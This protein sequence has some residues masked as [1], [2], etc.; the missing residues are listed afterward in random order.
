M[1][2]GV[3]IMK[4]PKLKSSFNKH[5]SYENWCKHKSQRNFCVNLLRKTKRQHF[6]KINIKNIANN[7]NFWKSIKP[8]F[9]A[10]G[11]ISS[12]ITLV[13]ND[14]IITNDRYLSKRMKNFY[15]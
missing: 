2:K 3:K 11:S 5:R 15:Y 7:R 10:K 1:N 6:N 12:K 9:S 4:K 8:H 13:E 14:T